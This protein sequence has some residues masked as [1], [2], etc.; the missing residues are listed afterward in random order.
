[1]VRELAHRFGQWES[2]PEPALATALRSTANR[3]LAL[4]Q[5]L[6]ADAAGRVV[7][8]YDTE[9]APGAESMKA[10]SLDPILARREVLRRSAAVL[11]QPR[12]RAGVIQR[13][14]LA[15]VIRRPDGTRYGYVGASVDVGAIRAQLGDIVRHSDLRLAVRDGRGRQLYP[16]RGAV[17]PGETSR[18]AGFIVTVWSGGGSFPWRRLAASLAA[19][20]CLLGA[21]LLLRR[22]D[23]RAQLGN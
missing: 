20:L 6:V 16:C 19:L 15:A 17:Q 11:V 7:A 5:L 23:R 21:A 3:H 10:G 8:G 14:E 2:L 22:L 1:M 9:Q 18:A 4:R 13:L 12:T